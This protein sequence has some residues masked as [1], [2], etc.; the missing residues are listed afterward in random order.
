MYALL[1]HTLIYIY[2]YINIWVRDRAYACD[3][4]ILFPGNLQVIFTSIVHSCLDKYPRLS[5]LPPGNSR[6]TPL[7]DSF[8]YFDSF[9]SPSF[10]HSFFLLLPPSFF[11]FSSFLSF[12]RPC[13]IVR[14]FLSIIHLQIC[15]FRLWQLIISIIASNVKI[16]HAFPVKSVKQFPKIQWRG[17]FFKFPFQWI[18]MDFRLFSARRNLSTIVNICEIILNRNTVSLT[19]QPNVYIEASINKRKFKSFLIRVTWFKTHN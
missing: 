19:V 2:I 1:T 3:A 8:S 5:L 4:D 11:F 6:H 15:F 12:I 17:L 10:P 7:R 9:S 16:Q 13:I 18:Y 14:L